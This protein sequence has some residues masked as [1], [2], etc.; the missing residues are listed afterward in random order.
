MNVVSH[1][2][3]ARLHPT[4]HHPES[5]QRLRVLLDR[6]EW[7]EVG[8]ARQADVLRCHDRRYVEQV[9][10]IDH[11]MWLDG[12]F[13]DCPFMAEYAQVAK[14]PQWVDEAAKQISVIGSHTRSSP[15]LPSPLSSARR[16]VVPRRPRVRRLLA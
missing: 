4:L 5:P 1:A 6:F 13:M 8:P 11:E 15:R 7:T 16:E 2:D 12:I 3:F 10:L 14:Q 9:E